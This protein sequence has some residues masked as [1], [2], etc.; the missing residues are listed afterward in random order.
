MFLFFYFKLLVCGPGVGYDE[1]EP[2][3]H[4][5][6]VGMGTSYIVTLRVWL[7]IVIA[8]IGQFEYMNDIIEGATTSIFTPTAKIELV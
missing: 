5:P 7:G 8:H 2:N 4:L 3:S 1:P 6:Q